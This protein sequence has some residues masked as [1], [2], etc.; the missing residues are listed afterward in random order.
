MRRV[1]IC[2]LESTCYLTWQR[3]L[4]RKTLPASRA[5]ADC[6]IRIGDGRGERLDNPAGA[7]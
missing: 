2:R 5:L 7:G 1:A 4:I 6:S 3:R